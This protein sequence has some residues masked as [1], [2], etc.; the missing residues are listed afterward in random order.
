MVAIVTIA[1]KTIFFTSVFISCVPVVR[2]M[3]LVRVRCHYCQPLNHYA[4]IFFRFPLRSP[5]FAKMQP[6][7]A[8]F[9]L[10]FR[11]RSPRLQRP[12]RQFPVMVIARLHGVQRV[13]IEP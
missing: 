8:L 9:A 11:V 5:T 10:S 2:L 4:S 12:G 6:A 3:V 13:H 7:I 1:I